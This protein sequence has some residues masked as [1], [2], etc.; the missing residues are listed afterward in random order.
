MTADELNQY[1][2]EIFPQM[3]QGEDGGY[4]VVDSGKNFAR[5]QM[6][7]HERHLRPGGTISGPSMMALADFAL[8][9]AILATLGPVPLAVT[10]NFSI[11]FLKKPSEGDLLGDCRL[12]KTGKRLVIGEVGV[13]SEGS[14]DLVAHVVGTYSVPP[15]TP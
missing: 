10:T 9:A 3:H 11:N 6:G 14:D 12:L 7:Y 13:S 8:Y 1:L 2:A 4:W 5:V 15:N